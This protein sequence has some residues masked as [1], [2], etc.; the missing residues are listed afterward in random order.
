MDSPTT[1]VVSKATAYF[2]PG[3]KSGESVH[4]R[5]DVAFDV[6]RVGVGKLLNAETDGGYAVEGQRLA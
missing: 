1:V 4:L 6:E 2:M 5:L 3:G